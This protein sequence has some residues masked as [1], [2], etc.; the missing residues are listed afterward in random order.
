M[1]Q[2]WLPGCNKLDPY[3]QLALCYNM[4]TMQLWSD[5]DNDNNNDKQDEQQPAT[6]PLQVTRRGQTH[7]LSE[8]SVFFTLRDW[9]L[10]DY[11]LSY[12]RALAA[13]HI[14]RRCY[15]ID[16]LGTG[17]TSGAKKQSE[18]S[19]PS[20]LASLSQ[21]LSALSR[22]L[23][24][25]NTPITLNGLVLKQGSSTRRDAHMQRQTMTGVAGDTTESAQSAQSALSSQRGRQGTTRRT[26]L[27]TGK[28]RDTSDPISA[29]WL[30][31]AP[32]LLQEVEQSPTLFLLNPFGHAVF[33]A[34][35]LNALYKR[36]AP[37]ELCLLLSY[38]Q[39][40]TLL[41]TALR[42]PAYA[43][44]LTA[45]LRTDKWKTLPVQ[46][47][48]QQKKQGEQGA[49]GDA[50]NVVIDLFMKAIQRH[51]TLP[52]QRIS[53]PVYMRP[54]VVETAPYALLFATRRQDSFA[55]MNDALCRYRRSVSAQSL[56]GV[57]AEEWFA[58]QQ[59]SRREEARLQLRDALVQRGKA[60][61]AR[62]WPDLRQQVLLDHF[63]Q[64]LLCEYD[65][66]LQTL[67][68][69]HTVSCEWRRNTPHDTDVPG[70]DD[71]LIW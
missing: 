23:A 69:N 27:N 4:H 8:Q 10:S 41:L 12:C 43:I 67:I 61:R 58:A 9:L 46:D 55:Y 70:N 2:E 18:L 54:A 37:T 47:E 45:V 14:Y 60:Q 57:L 19:T 51:F 21:S 48:A 35:D 65:E 31:A 49:W 59:Q 15:L 5:L 44:A 71:L 36:T 24:Q 56:R 17:G 53:L 3:R 32:M 66:V 34:N 39:V 26:A 1:I 64:F 68:A 33:T 6:R 7:R 52:V 20:S 62:R 25:E 29:S 30:E 42:S 40:E 63:G 22:M 38:K 13:T 16:G 28:V 50:V 11:V